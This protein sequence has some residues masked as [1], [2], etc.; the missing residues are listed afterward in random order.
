[1]PGEK[2][3]FAL[4]VS[5]LLYV[6]LCIIAVFAQRILAYPWWIARWI[7]KNDTEMSHFSDVVIRT[8]DGVSINA[9]WLPPRSPDCDVVITFH[10]IQGCP[11]YQA[12][13]FSR[14]HWSKSGC[15]VLAPAFRGYHGSGGW[16]SEAGLMM[17]AEA[18]FDFVRNEAAASS[19]VLHG[20]SLGSGVATA[21]STRFPCKALILESPFTSLPDVG[22][23]WYPFFPV[24]RFMKDLF[25]TLSLIRHV[26]ADDIYI[27]HG[28]RDRLIPISMARQVA[29]AREGIQFFPLVGKGHMNLCVDADAV[30]EKVLARKINAAPE[31]TQL[32]LSKG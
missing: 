15:G 7:K 27:L 11:W 17:D 29:V 9:L 13:R 28:E 23:R 6:A 26:Q 16:P 32:K 4:L 18:C 10:G 12:L 14:G 31:D 2:I 30:L 1:M 21:T 3:V 24:R 25:P 8:A 22:S 5:A 19:I 20:H